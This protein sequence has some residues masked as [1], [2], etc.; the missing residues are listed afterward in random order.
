[1]KGALILITIFSRVK[2]KAKQV[3]GLML[4]ILIAAVAE[5]LLPTMLAKMINKGVLGANKSTVSILSIV[6]L[7]ITI[8]ACGINFLSVKLSSKISTDFSARLRGECF[9][10]FRIFPPLK[11]TNLELQA[12]LPEV[13]QT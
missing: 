12:L 11:W 7:G 9:A 2:L 13:P 8:V 5:M 10:Q 3:A 6:M 1:M 4:L